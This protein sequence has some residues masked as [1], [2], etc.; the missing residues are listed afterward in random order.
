MFHYNVFV[1]CCDYLKDVLDAHDEKVPIS[2]SLTHCINNDS[3][4]KLPCYN[5][6]QEERILLSGKIV[7]VRNDIVHGK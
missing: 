4:V 7:L 2:D 3:G 5:T 1:S 6:Q